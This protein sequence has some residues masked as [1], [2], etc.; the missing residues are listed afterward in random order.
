MKSNFGVATFI[1][2]QMKF[3]LKG[4][5][6]YVAPFVTYVASFVI[7]GLYSRL[8][9]AA[10]VCV[11]HLSFHHYAAHFIQGHKAVALRVDREDSIAEVLRL[12]LSSQGLLCGHAYCWME[13]SI[14]VRLQ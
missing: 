1:Y 9:S 6:N 11:C 13:E 10:I 7:R 12:G 8:L 3:A 2:Q 5:D 4:Q 14:L